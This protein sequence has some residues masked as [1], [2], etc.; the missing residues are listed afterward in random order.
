[1]HAW[2][3]HIWDDD[4]RGLAADR[5][6]AQNMQEQRLAEEMHH[7]LCIEALKGSRHILVHVARDG[8]VES[9]GA[10]LRGGNSCDGQH[11]RHAIEPCRAL[12]HSR[13][14]IDVLPPSGRVGA[15]RF[16]D[17]MLSAAWCERADCNQL[18]NA[19]PT[20]CQQG[21]AML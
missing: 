7:L 16:V 15:C 6:V 1:M 9:A 20:L 4:L 21:G 3:P 10:H 8:P 19:T 14:E 18:N 5:A 11:H 13:S 2:K 12:R 17:S